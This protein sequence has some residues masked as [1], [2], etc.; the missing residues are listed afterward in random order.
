M[1]LAF[2]THTPKEYALEFY[3]KNGDVLEGSIGSDLAPMIQD[4]HNRLYFVRSS[5]ETEQADH[6]VL[7][8]C[9]IN[10]ESELKRLAD[11]KTV[12]MP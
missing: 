7:F 12:A 2:H 3:D 11:I 10:T 6:T 4:S 8:R 5:S 9:S 1:L